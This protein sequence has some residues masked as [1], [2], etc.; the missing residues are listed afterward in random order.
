M[1]AFNSTLLI[2]ACEFVERKCNRYNFIVYSSTNVVSIIINTLHLFVLREIPRVK[3]SNY[4]WILFNI[5]LG[6]IAMSIAVI[7]LVNC[8]LW[9]LRNCFIMVMS[10][11]SAGIVFQVRYWLLTLAVLD[12][13]YAVCKP[14]QYKTSKFINNIGKWAAVAWTLSIVLAFLLNFFRH[15]RIAAV[16]SEVER[17]LNI[18]VIAAAVVPSLIS[19][20]LL[21]RIAVELK[22]MKQ[23][24]NPTAEDPETLSANRYIIGVFIMFYVSIIP[25]FVHAGFEMMSKNSPETDFSWLTSTALFTHL[26]Y[27]VGNVVLYGILNKAYVAKIK[28]ICGSLCPVA[29]VSPQ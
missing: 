19:T 27:G 3:E 1:E 28:S 9:V 10:Y 11:A 8:N 22:R 13:Y 6:D 15:V 21:L 14:F 24:K 7:L 16:Q 20:V 18:A 5:T 12:R 17:Y 23:Q 4:F 25:S 29:K 26:L 2:D